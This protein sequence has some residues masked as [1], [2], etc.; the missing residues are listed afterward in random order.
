M[1]ASLLLLVPAVLFA[2]GG[3]VVLVVLTL[4]ARP[5]HTLASEVASARRHGLVTSVLAATAFVATV[6]FLIA[7]ASRPSDGYV[8]L[9]QGALP[10]TGAVV[11]LLVLAL[12]ELT[13]PRPRGLQRQVN[14]NPR[15]LSD[16][17]PPTWTRIL[18][19]L[20][21]LTV[22][23]I[24]FGWWAAHPYGHSLVRVHEGGLQVDSA[25]P[26]PGSDYGIPQLVAL[27]VALLSLYGVLRLVV[28]RPAVVRSDVATDNRLR[29]ASA[30]RAIR[31]VV[32]ALALTAAGNLFFGG[33]TGLRL[34][35]PGWQQN[36]SAAAMLVGGSLGVV[37]IL[38]VLAPAPRLPKADPVVPPAPA[39]TSS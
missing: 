4:T 8:R 36:L 1:A 27:G 10:L 5:D 17:V 12:G 15:T 3:L 23:V 37:G 34:Y 13:W 38:L 30:V 26:F 7:L 28:L 14:L 2:T 29:A 35:D 24:G 25:S 21:V 31:V 33:T 20:T 19:G 16:L 18:V 9:L 32:S 6:A 22:A 39:T 11:A